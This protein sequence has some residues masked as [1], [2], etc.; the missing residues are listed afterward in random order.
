MVSV[1]LLAFDLVF[2]FSR[3][4]SILNVKARHFPFILAIPVMLAFGLNNPYIES[5]S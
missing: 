5:G 2:K 4:S 1:C 3:N